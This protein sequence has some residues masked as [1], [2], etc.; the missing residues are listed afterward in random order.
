VNAPGPEIV[1]VGS[2]NRDLVVTV[3]EA[4]GAGETVL[5]K[6]LR[7]FHGGKGANQ[8]YAA[9]RLGARVAFA[10]RVGSEPEA[11]EQIDALARA[12]VDTRFLTRD[13]GRPGG[14]AI[15]VVDARKENRIIVVPGANGGFGP[16]GLEAC[17]GIL[18]AARCVLLQLEIPMET[19]VAAA[20]IARE[21]GALV[22]LDPAPARP[23]PPELL[24]RADYLTPNLGEL[25][26]LT[27]A[28]LGTDSSIEEIAAA[29]RKLCGRGERKTIAKL[30]ARGALLVSAAGEHLQPAFAVRAVDTTGAGDCFN[31]AFAAALVRGRSE[32]EALAFAAAAAA[33][34]VTRP[35]AQAGMPSL[36]DVEA[37]L[38]S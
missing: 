6:D 18:A 17:R 32:A 23:L 24:E 37:M 31:A 9:G 30:G 29:A 3:S 10:G 14:T 19:V 21:G 35:G 20:G 22:I 34:S 1:V 7:T 4:P 27:G 38:G 8:A 26:I 15:I 28:S 13:P 25:S 5:G 36:Q 12:G 2:I 16:D 11:R 33:C